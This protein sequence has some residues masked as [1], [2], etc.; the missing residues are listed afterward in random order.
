MLNDGG[1]LIAVDVAGVAGAAPVAHGDLVAVLRGA[2]DAGIGAL[3]GIFLFS[4]GPGITDAGR[5]RFSLSS[6]SVTTHSKAIAPAPASTVQVIGRMMGL[7][8][9]KD[10]INTRCGCE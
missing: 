9:V 4:D 1:L 6:H 8:P 2:S 7:L 3:P 10:Q 5:E